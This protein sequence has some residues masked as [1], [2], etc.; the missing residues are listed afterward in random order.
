MKPHLYLAAP[1]VLFGLVACTGTPQNGQIP[2][3]TYQLELLGRTMPT[4]SEFTQAL[5]ADYLALAQYEWGEYDWLAQQIFAKKGLAAAAGTAVPPESLEEWSVSD[6][7]AAADLKVARTYL[8]SVLSSN[9]PRLFPRWMSTAQ[10]KFDC[11]LHEQHEGWETERIKEC[12]DAFRTA[13]TQIASGKGGPPAVGPAPAAAAPVGAAPSSFLVFFDFDRSDI[14]PEASRI[15]A[16]A[17][18]AIAAKPA[19]SVRVVG[20]T[21]TSGRPDYN[22][23]LSLRRSLAVEQDLIRNG[24]A[25]S[26]IHH[27]GRGEGDLLLKTEDGVREPQNRRATIELIQP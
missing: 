7:V 12:R 10:T 15:L 20:Y 23:K 21:D 19:S 3:S 13:I 4:G 24:V 2:G 14:T 26:K 16:A 6:P 22:L 11:W 27:D 25:A 9:A 8:I 17:A 18:K 5:T 1:I